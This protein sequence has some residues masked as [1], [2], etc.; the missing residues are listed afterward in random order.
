MTNLSGA[1]HDGLRRRLGNLG[2]IAFLL[3][4]A[5]LA[6]VWQSADFAWPSPG[7][8][9]WLGALV[10]V[11]SYLGACA[12]FL[13]G[14][15]GHSSASAI[16]DA[17]SA[18]NATTDDLVVTYASQTG[19]ARQLGLRTLEALRA[20][21]LN[22]SL[23]PIGEL[24]PAR[25]QR[26]RRI[27]IVVST[28]GEG[29]APDMAAR[30]IG[31]VLHSELRLDQLQYG[32]LALGDSEYA[33]FCAFGHAIDAWLQRVGARPMFDL[34]EVDDGDPGALRHWQY[35]LGQLSG[36]SDLPDWQ[37]PE[38]TRC[39]L[40][41]RELVN[42][43]STGDPCFRIALGPADLPLPHWL[44]GDIAEIGPQN[45][46]A[47][48]EAWLDRHDLDGDAAIVVHGKPG[49]LRT[50]A[51]G[52]ALD[53][54]AAN[55]D[56][57]ALADALTRLP[58]RDYSIASIP[59]D[60]RIE[61]LLRQWRRA[62]GSLGLGTGWLT[63]HAGLG[64]TVSLR[65][66]SNAAFHAPAADV[67]LLLIGN[68]TGIASLRALIR[69]RIV[70]GRR[71]NWLIFG[72]RNADRD[73]HFREEILGW[74]ENAA[75]ARLDLAFSRDQA[76]PVYVQHRLLAAA[77]QVREWVE[78]GAEILVCGSLAGM[79]PGVDKA[80]HDILGEARVIELATAGRYRRDVY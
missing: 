77:Q 6:G 20:G 54:P 30:F 10:L 1:G 39:V 24:D 15:A 64:E 46:T 45:P 47:Q 59:A 74:Q 41:E 58:H 3:V 38:Y 48:V 32:V 18:S 8:T 33:N 56:A 71:R 55:T 26:I 17:A 42:P 19:H 5:V 72:E 69:Q 66:R 65:I 70:E 43:G 53:D 40:L 22:V 25:L 44:A 73:F 16:P 35:R 76:Q 7:S 23:H 4:L 50:H 78:A 36:R 63:H 51:A 61:L 52:C 9:R 80:L 37:V 49:T 27:L 31:S 60:G 34:I 29:D 2:L 67:P 57:Q 62:D 11:A 79:A 21:G 13:C 12:V 14:S 75:L 28:T 68:G